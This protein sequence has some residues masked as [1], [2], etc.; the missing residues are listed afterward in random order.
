AAP[1]LRLDLALGHG[2]AR[3]RAG[4]RRRP[5][6][7]WAGGGAGDRRPGRAGRHS[8]GV[9]RQYCGELGKRANCQSLVSL[10]LAKAEVPVRIGL[11]LF[12]PEGWGA[13]AERLARV[14]APEGIGYRP[15]WRIA[16]D[17]IDRVLAAGARFGCILAD[18]A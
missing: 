8:V 16:L 6:R 9:Q 13:D 17:E 10:T 12:L 5:A 1:S 18:A 2:P 7:R 4:A 11:R 14:G 3:R 15:K